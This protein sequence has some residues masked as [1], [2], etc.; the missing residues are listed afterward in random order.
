MKNLKLLFM[1]LGFSLLL[2]GCVGGQTDD[3]TT[4]DTVKQTEKSNVSDVLDPFKSKD[5]NY[6]Y[7]S[8]QLFL[9]YY[10]KTWYADDSKNPSFQFFS[11]AEDSNDKILEEVIVEI[12]SGNESTTEQFEVYERTLMV[13]G[14]VITQTENVT[15]KEKP[16]FV[17]EM[18]GNNPDTGTRMVYKTLFFRN[19]EWVYR[20]NYSVEKSKISS[21]R[22]IMENILD[23]FVVGTG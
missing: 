13:Q 16:T 12:W 7:Y 3:T 4:K 23:K 20:I 15:Y 22:P 1:I 10:P 21:Y 2:F 18:E 5:P 9:I 6:T 8:S 11:P 19:G 17:I 14:D